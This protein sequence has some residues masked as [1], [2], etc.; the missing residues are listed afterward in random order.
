M[1]VPD[2]NG[3]NDYDRPVI[4]M[5]PDEE[6]A[7]GEEL[8][9][10]VCSHSSALKNPLPHYYIAL[11]YQPQGKVRTKLKKPTVAICTWAIPVKRE[12]IKSCGGTVP[13]GTLEL[14]IDKARECREAG[15]TDT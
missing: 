13:P 11:P 9:G 1:G 14:I 8:Y 7:N 15:I 4:I 5:T 12:S 3:H 6:I 2:G 10:I